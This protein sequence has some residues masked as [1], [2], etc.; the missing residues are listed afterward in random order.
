MEPVAVDESVIAAAP[1]GVR[2]GRQAGR[3]ARRRSSSPVSDGERVAVFVAVP[4][5]DRDWL[6][7]PVL[8]AVASWLRLC[9]SDDDTEAE[10]DWDGVELANP[11]GL[12]VAVG[13]LDP[14]S[15]GVGRMEGLRDGL[16][17]WE[18]V[19]DSE[20]VDVPES[21]WDGEGAPDGVAVHEDVS[22]CVAVPV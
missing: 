6:A 19:P 8:L 12:E 11:D 5:P 20:G 7:D 9:D 15:E 18:G 3:R 14:D 21:D 1:R 16:E 10:A 22:V 17:L 4:D 13:E 2:P